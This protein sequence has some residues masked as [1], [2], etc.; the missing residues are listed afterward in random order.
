MKRENNQLQGLCAHSHRRERRW[1][2][3]L[4]EMYTT[5]L[6]TTGNSPPQQLLQ[7][8]YYGYGYSP[9]ATTVYQPL[10]QLPYTFN[11]SSQNTSAKMIE[12]VLTLFDGRGKL[13][14]DQ[15]AIR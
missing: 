15:P 13:V 3:L 14:W 2:Y 5:R 8:A 6:P 12:S 11:N 4:S 10:L 9:M 1:V 7:P